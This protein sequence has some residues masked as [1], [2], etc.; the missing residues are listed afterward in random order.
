[1]FSL[2]HPIGP[3]TFSVASQ[4]VS[5]FSLWFHGC[6]FSC[7]F[8]FHFC[9]HG[10]S[11]NGFV[12]VAGPLTPPAS[13]SLHLHSISLLSHRAM[14]RATVK[15]AEP[16]GAIAA[17]EETKK[18]EME[19]RGQWSSKV[20]FVLSVAGE[21]IGLG[22]VWRFPYLCYKNGGGKLSAKVVL[23]LQALQD[24]LVSGPIAPQ[25]VLLLKATLLSL[26]YKWI[27][28]R[29]TLPLRNSSRFL[30]IQRQRWS[31]KMSCEGSESQ[32]QPPSASL[33]FWF[34]LSPPALSGPCYRGGKSLMMPVSL[35]KPGMSFLAPECP[36][37]SPGNLN[38]HLQLSQGWLPCGYEGNTAFYYASITQLAPEVMEGT[39]WSILSSCIGKYKTEGP[40]LQ[41]CVRRVFSEDGKKKDAATASP[42]AVLPVVN[43]L[44]GKSVPGKNL[45]PSLL[46]LVWLPLSQ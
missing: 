35:L 1:M 28:R 33:P 43:T 4:S 46:F 22:N 31:S 11:R 24:T 18:E 8:F 10:D 41:T 34:Y 44:L 12:V 26:N 15:K 9:T 5:E 38:F 7:K 42:G 13:S 6:A 14:T 39:S 30:G 45:F 36:L 17:P 2:F 23:G 32:Q 29:G 16:N 19:E 40:S 3:A 21:I 25:W 20:E 37:L 27:F